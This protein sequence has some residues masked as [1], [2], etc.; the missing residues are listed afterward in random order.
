M[1]ILYYNWVQFDDEEKR[2]GG[3]TV[4][5][6]NLIGGMKD[7]TDVYFL[8]SGM[9]YT[10]GSR[11][12]IRR[13]KNCFGNKCKSFE[14]VN[15]PILA[16][17]INAY[18]T[19][20]TYL[21]DETLLELLVEFMKKEGPFDVVHFNNIEGLSINVLKV[22]EF[23]P[24]TRIFF[25]LH[26]Y[27]PVCPQVNLWQSEKCNCLDNDDARSCCFCVTDYAPIGF[28]RNCNILAFYL[29]KWHIK[30]ES[31]LWRSSFYCLPKIAGFIKK[32][33]RKGV[34]PGL[35][36]IHSDDNRLKYKAFIEKNVEYLN[37]YTDTILAVSE[38]VKEIAVR[39]GIAEEKLCVSYI[40]T[41]AAESQIG[42]CVA[43]I[44]SEELKIAYLGYARRDKG[45]FF[46]LKAL[47]DVPKEYAHK[48]DLLLC[49]K[50]DDNRVK[51]AIQEL[52][53]KYH[54]VL[55]KNG[56]NQ[57]EMK[58]LLEGVNLGIVP[59][60]WE[61]NLPQVA[62]EIV[63]LG[64]P[65]LTSDLGGAKE[66]GRNESFVFSAG[67]KEDFVKKLLSIVN[68]REKLDSFW[69][70]AMPLVTIPEHVSELLDLYGNTRCS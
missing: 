42:R 8:S 51:K 11:T 70:K 69:N 17:A 52:G 26:N 59:V 57:S 16:P 50:L 48:I 67:D 62:I 13:T 56:Y 22:K 21:N 39:R 54:S 20:D 44:Y 12:R 9:S 19:I 68:E 28:V 6:K 65:I 49:V 61:D 5:L 53:N 25:S 27:Y 4:Y 29:K 35:Q 38:R 55:F 7:V 3:V 24:Q 30:P 34:Y 43:N 14:I 60:M 32:Q 31:F 46:L 47:K 58:E 37:R 10:I 63:S 40:G 33:K 2:G 66:I 23:F 18:K 1:K 15:S 45:F 64:I 36:I 41:K